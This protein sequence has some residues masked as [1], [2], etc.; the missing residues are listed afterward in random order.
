MSFKG[1]ISISAILAILALLNE[2]TYHGG[3]ETGR[4]Q[5]NQPLIFADVADQDLAANQHERT[6][7]KTNSAKFVGICR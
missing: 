7:I 4:R 6:R 1:L 2:K 3:M 5:K